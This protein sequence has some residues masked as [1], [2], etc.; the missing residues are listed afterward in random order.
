MHPRSCTDVLF[1]VLLC[2]AWIGLLLLG[3]LAFS[4]AEVQSSWRYITTGVDYLGR[5]C[6][7]VAWEG[8]AGKNN[9]FLY[10]PD[11]EKNPD[12]GVCIEACP[13]SRDILHVAVETVGKDILNVT[14]ETYETT[15]HTYLCYPKDGG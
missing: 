8:G 4:G 2:L 15:A 1:A 7:M 12:F 14:F 10:F 5:G 9:K 13:K 3:V 11:V 6:G